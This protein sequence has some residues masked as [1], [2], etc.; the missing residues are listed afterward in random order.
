MQLQFRK[1]N[2]VLEIFETVEKLIGIES[3]IVNI[4]ICK[5]M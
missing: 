4:F 3:K 2:F 1:R 5:E